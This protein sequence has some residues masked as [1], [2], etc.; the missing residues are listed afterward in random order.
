MLRNFKK[1]RGAMV[2]KRIFSLFVIILC[3]FFLF[4]HKE[5]FSQAGSNIQPFK[6]DTNAQQH[7]ENQVIRQWTAHYKKSF[8]LEDLHAYKAVALGLPSA[9]NVAGNPQEC[10]DDLEDLLWLNNLGM[11]R[12]SAFKGSD[13]RICESLKKS[14]CSDLEKDEALLCQAFLNLDA[15]SYKKGLAYN[16]E[17]EEEIEIYRQLAFYSAF[18]NG[19][20]GSC[21]QLI[22]NEDSYIYK[23]GCRVALSSEPE[24]IIDGLA[25]DFAYYAYSESKGKR[26]LC[27][28]INDIL[29]REKC[30]KGVNLPSFIDRY[31]L[32][33]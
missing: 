26:D 14:D 4:E 22:S 32:E 28:K 6:P 10:K 20:V 7:N 8:Y 13:R 2:K 5:I 33:K 31:F 11:G 25:L 19:S 23:L 30:K 29:L 17:K 9:C 21:T 24:K 3:L 1:G 16:K 12:C 15:E 27:D 18:K